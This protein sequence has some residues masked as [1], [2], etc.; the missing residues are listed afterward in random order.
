MFSTLFSH[1]NQFYSNT[2]WGWILW[3]RNAYMSRIISKVYHLLK[4]NNKIGSI[5]SVCSCVGCFLISLC[6]G[7][8]TTIL[9]QYQSMVPWMLQKH[10]MHLP[11]ALYTYLRMPRGW[12]SMYQLHLKPEA[13]QFHNGS[14]CAHRRI[15]V[16]KK[17]NNNKRVRT[18]KQRPNTTLG[19]PTFTVIP[20]ISQRVIWISFEKNQTVKKYFLWVIVGG[21]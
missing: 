21:R 20:F 15:K 2:H 19:E 7:F 6:W 10:I 5:D 14:M 4:I 1:L 8:F 18:E 13:C 11:A 9:I 17:N 12:K 3:I 16:K